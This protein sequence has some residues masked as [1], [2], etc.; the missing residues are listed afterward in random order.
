[1][2]LN[3][4]KKKRFW[5]GDKRIRWKVAVD[6]FHHCFSRASVEDPRPKGGNELGHPSPFVSFEF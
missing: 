2:Q 5:L 1:M 3:L 6:N 4:K